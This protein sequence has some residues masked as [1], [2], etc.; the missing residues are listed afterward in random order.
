[1]AHLRRFGANPMSDWKMKRFWDAAAAVE[2]DGGYTVHL[3][4]RSIK[5]P[6]KA[7]LIVPTRVMAEAMALEWDAQDKVINPNT[8][9]VT[10]SAIS[11]VDKVAVQF[12][13]VADML[14]EYAGTDLLC[15]RAKQPEELIQK[16]AAGWDPLLEWCATTFE[17]PLLPVAGVRFAEQPE[18]SL[19]VLRRL[20]DPMSTFELTAMHDLVTLPGSFVVAL[21]AIHD[22]ATPEDLWELSRLDE[23]YQQQ[24]WGTD[25][26]AE[27]MAGIKRD[28]FKHAYDFYQMSRI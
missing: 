11:A 24:Q 2:V 15:Y 27:E 1:M 13:D 5:T 12:D 26:D 16:Q 4:G 18:S 9:P 20:L 28:A 7:A 19:Q 10:K 23:R 6:G 25:D 22:I 3:D 17:A 14:G 21:A 8:M